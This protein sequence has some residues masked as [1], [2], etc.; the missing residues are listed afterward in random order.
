MVRD[1]INTEF[2]DSKQE[3]EIEYNEDEENDPDPFSHLDS[4]LN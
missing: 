1:E 3:L 2:Y 4:M